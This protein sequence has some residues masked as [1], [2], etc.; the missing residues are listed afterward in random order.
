MLNHCLPGAHGLVSL[1][2]RWFRTLSGASCPGTKYRDCNWGALHQENVPRSLIP[3]LVSA[4]S[5]RPAGRGSIV[6]V[7]APAMAASEGVGMIAVDARN[8]A[9]DDRSVADRPMKPVIGRG[10]VPA[11]IVS[12]AMI[13][14]SGEVKVPQD[15]HG[16]RRDREGGA[17][18]AARRG[19]LPVNA[20][21]EVVITREEATDADAIV[22]IGVPTKIE[23]GTV[24]RHRARE[25]RMVGA[26]EGTRRL[27]MTVA[28]DGGRF[29]G[30]QRQP[31]GLAV[32]EVLE[33]VFSRLAGNR[34]VHVIGAGRTDAGVHA[35]GQIAHVDIDWSGDPGDLLRRASRMLPSDIALRSLSDAPAGFHARFSASQRHY[36][37]AIIRHADPFKAR[38]AWHLDADLDE[39]LLRRGAES[40]SGQ[41]DFTGLSKV[42][43]DT[44]NPRCRVSISRWS[45]VGGELHFDIA[46]D[47]FLYGMVRLI[48]GLLVEVARHRRPQDDVRRAIQECDR[49]LQSP[50]APARGLALVGVDYPA[51]S[52]ETIP[53]FLGR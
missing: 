38:Y 19:A 2:K 47:R 7:V 9:K 26:I 14:A 43:P 21:A 8:S 22:K 39:S 44:L 24:V 11:E 29:V 53:H 3:S 4:F 37:Y 46:A 27:V 40:L 23:D 41:H 36:T 51:V 16:T 31:N 49:A 28:Y 18:M 13:V 15:R 33:S 50:M 5:G 20:P 17:L 34:P 35:R 1:T 52:N 42:N 45:I 48:V 30:W 10:I 12:N 32:Q 25:N 6:R